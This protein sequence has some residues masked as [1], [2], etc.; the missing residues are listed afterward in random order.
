MKK[1]FLLTVVDQADFDRVKHES[2]WFDGSA[3]EGYAHGKIDE[4]TALDLQAGFLH[5]QFA[6]SIK[7]LEIQDA[8]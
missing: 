3:A 5:S 1:I 2:A 4:L 7:T 6:Y 8:Q